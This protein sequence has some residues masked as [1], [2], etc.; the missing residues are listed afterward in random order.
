MQNISDSWTPRSARHLQSHVQAIAA[1]FVCIKNNTDTLKKN[2]LEPL[3]LTYWFILPDHTHPIFI[4]FHE[5][6]QEHFLNFR[7]VTN[8]FKRGCSGTDI[9]SKNSW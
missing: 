6:F 1:F 3:E 4:D 9:F 8:L 5:S 7:E 2:G